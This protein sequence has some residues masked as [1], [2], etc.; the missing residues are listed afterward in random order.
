MSFVESLEALGVNVKEGVDRVM[1]DQEL[2]ETMLD[3]LVEEVESYPIN[4]KDF[5]NSDY[6]ELTKRVHMLKGTTG[7]LSIT[8]LFEGYEKALGL[9]RN[10]Q[11]GEAK[12]VFEKVLPVQ[13]KIIDCIKNR[14]SA[15][16]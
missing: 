13:A 10:K 12:A 16:L 11:P 6:D 7:N 5:D 1:G 2:Y 3:M 15:A 8:P 4:L 14:G 9:L